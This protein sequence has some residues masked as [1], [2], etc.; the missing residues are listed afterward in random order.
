MNLFTKLTLVLVIFILARNTGHAQV[1]YKYKI[2]F[3]S[4]VADQP[5]EAKLFLQRYSSTNLI[6]GFNVDEA[7]ITSLK[8]I[9]KNVLSGKLEKLK[10]PVKSI[11]LL[12]IIVN[13]SSS[14]RSATA[15]VSEKEIQDK[16]TKSQQQQIEMKNKQVFAEPNRRY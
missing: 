10:A 2:V 14:E 1:M 4:A 9:N 6:N 8:Q 5:N 12:D 7:I 11:D 13:T 3:K 16:T 15:P